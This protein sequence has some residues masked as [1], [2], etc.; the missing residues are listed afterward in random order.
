M[1]LKSL[2]MLLPKF[3]QFKTEAIKSSITE[4]NL[5]EGSG[6]PWAGQRRDSSWPHL[7][8]NVELSDSCE[9][10]GLVPPIGSKIE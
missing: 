3:L 1:L 2:V 8:V 6:A 4:T 7:L 9:N 10:F 5:N